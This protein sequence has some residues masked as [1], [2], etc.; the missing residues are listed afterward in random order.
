MSF[1]TSSR[2]ALVRRI[3]QKL[4]NFEHREIR[5]V[6]REVNLVANQIAK[7]VSVEMEGV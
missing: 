5:H 1:I 6:P 7:M 3:Q 2:L 4:Q